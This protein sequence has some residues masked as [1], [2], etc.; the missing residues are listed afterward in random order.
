MKTQTEKKDKYH[1]SKTNGFFT[2]ET[3][4]EDLHFRAYCPT[5]MNAN[6]FYLLSMEE[7]EKIVK[8]VNMHDELVDKLKDTSKFLND[9]ITGKH[10]FLEEEYKLFYLSLLQLLKQAE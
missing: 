9:A 1:L 2:I 7:G 10:G 4:N 5:R 6:E 3:T 8:A